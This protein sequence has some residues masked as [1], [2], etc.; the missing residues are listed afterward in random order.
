MQ[1]RREVLA[2]AICMTSLALVAGCD[3][4]PKPASTATLFNKEEV[5]GAI[6]ELDSQI[7]ALEEDVEAFDSE[8]WRD[9]VPRIKEGAESVRGALDNLKKALG[10]SS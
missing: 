3:S 7:G 10:Y 1:T 8:N 5:H 9:L 4:E 2:A 6:Q